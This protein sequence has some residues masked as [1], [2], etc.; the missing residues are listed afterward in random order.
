[1]QVMDLFRVLIKDTEFS[2]TNERPWK[3]FKTHTQTYGDSDY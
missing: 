1:M 2:E 3:K